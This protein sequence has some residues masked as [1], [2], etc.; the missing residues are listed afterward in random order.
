MIIIQKIDNPSIS[1]ILDNIVEFTKG[2][3]IIT[4]ADTYT[5]WH[6]I[7]FRDIGGKFHQWDY[8]KTDKGEKLRDK[9]YQEIIN[10]T[11]DK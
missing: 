1:I 2:N 3:A 7:N 8:G 10:I 5:G 11:N 4:C 9:Q 6:T